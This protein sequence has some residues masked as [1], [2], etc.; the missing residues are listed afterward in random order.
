[1]QR[2]FF[3][4]RSIIEN[5]AS[6]AS[7]CRFACRPVLFGRELPYQ[8]DLTGY[9]S[10]WEVNGTTWAATV[11]NQDTSRDCSDPPSD[12]KQIDWKTAPRHQA[13][14][15]LWH[16]SCCRGSRLWEVTDRSNIAQYLLESCSNLARI[17]ALR[18]GQESRESRR[19][20]LA[21]PRQAAAPRW[22][23]PNIG[24]GF[25]PSTFPGAI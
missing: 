24:E 10:T 21:V 18:D 5:P 7:R 6:F 12:P 13:G 4:P 8:A 11:S 25:Q 20:E 17:L 16:G 19:A 2:R 22:L 14:K 3:A 1:M 15:Q 9:L 23:A